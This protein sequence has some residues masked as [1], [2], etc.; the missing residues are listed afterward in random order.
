MAID[1]T[2]SMSLHELVLEVARRCNLASYINPDDATDNRA[3]V[4][5]DPH[6]LEEMKAAVSRGYRRFLRDMWDATFMRVWVPLTISTST[7]GPNVLDGEP[8]R[9]VLPRFCSSAPIGDW[10][11][12]GN[13]QVYTSIK[14]MDYRI[15]AQYKEH[16]AGT[17]PTTG[18]PTSAGHRRIE[19]GGERRWEV[20]FYPQPD[21][22]YSVQAEFAIMPYDLV[23]MAERHIAG[24]AHDDTIIAAA[25]YEY[26]AHDEPALAAQFMAMYQDALAGSRRIDAR[27]KTTNAGAR[28][29][30]DHFG[31]PPHVLHSDPSPTVL[32]NGQPA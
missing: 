22:S 15:V 19:Q 14:S 29:V 4:P 2:N 32:V 31:T 28:R 13:N 7:S 8:D 23:E 30:S 9:Y 6:D 21:Q 27:S 17:A 24:Q 12:V 20:L 18:A 16:G 3:R 1:L 26:K 10:L 5:S 11:Y 25:V